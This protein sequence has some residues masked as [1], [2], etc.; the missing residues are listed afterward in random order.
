VLL[1]DTQPYEERKPSTEPFLP[2]E[3]T[4]YN[5]ALVESDESKV[6]LSLCLI[7]HCPMTMYS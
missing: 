2:T 5:Q 4:R 1:A 6:V 3:Q 7:N